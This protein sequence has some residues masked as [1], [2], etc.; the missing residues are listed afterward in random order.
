MRNEI[1]NFHRLNNR[2]LFISNQ[3]KQK[4]NNGNNFTIKQ[5][6]KTSVAHWQFKKK[7]DKLLRTLQN[8]T[9]IDFNI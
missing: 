6:F 8:K 7:T 2:N 3:N 9:R 4:E 1:Q 5:E